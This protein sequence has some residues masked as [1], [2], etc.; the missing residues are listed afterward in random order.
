MSAVDFHE[1]ERYESKTGKAVKVVQ[2]D[3]L[4]DKVRIQFEDSGSARWVVADDFLSKY[5]PVT[6]TEEG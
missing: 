5:R 2:I 1:G 3:S 4:A 6:S